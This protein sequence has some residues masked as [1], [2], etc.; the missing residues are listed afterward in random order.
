MLEGRKLSLKRG[1]R[2][3]VSNDNVIS[4]RRCPRSPLKIEIKNIR[5]PRAHNEETEIFI[6]AATSEGA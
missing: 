3:R 1:W 6:V 4:R 5:I 2:E